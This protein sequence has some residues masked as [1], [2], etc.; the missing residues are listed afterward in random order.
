MGTLTKPY[1][2]TGGTF[3][4]AAQVNS[5]FDTLYSW[6]NTNAIWAD[7]STAFTGIPTGPNSDPLSGNQ[8]TRKSYVDQYLWSGTTTAPTGGRFQYRV[9][10]F[11]AVTTDG[12]GN[13]TMSFSSAF[14]NITN[15]VFFTIQSN[16][17]LWVNPVTY[18]TSSVTGRVLQGPSPYY[19][20]GTFYIGYF[21]L[22]H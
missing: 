7:A 3:A 2:F 14:P 20:T 8:F 6:V 5:D 13:F 1:V 18:T 22:G 9:S 17:S 12:V 16:A 11:T 19:D 15:V 4:V 21:A 10:P